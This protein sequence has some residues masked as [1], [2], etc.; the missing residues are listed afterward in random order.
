MS[1]IRTKVLIQWRVQWL[2]FKI[3]LTVFE[4]VRTDATLDLSQQAEKLLELAVFKEHHNF[5][6]NLNDFNCCI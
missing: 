1:G 2:K 6:R 5:L 4:L 3:E